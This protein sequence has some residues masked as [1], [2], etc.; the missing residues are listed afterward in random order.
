MKWFDDIPMVRELSL[1]RVWVIG[2][3]HGCLKQMMELT[4]AITIRQDNPDR[5]AMVFV[6]DICDRGPSSYLTLSTLMF[7]RSSSRYYTVLGNHDSKLLRKLTGK[8][9]KLSNGLQQTWDEIEANC[10]AD[11][12]AAIRRFFEN[13][14]F[15]IRVHTPKGDCVIAHAGFHQ[16]FAGHAGPWTKAMSVQ[17]AIFGPTDGVLEDGFPNRLPWENDYDGEDFVFYGHKAVGK[18][19]KFVGMTC[20]VDTG[21]WESGI[22]TAVSYPDLDVIQVSSN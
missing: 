16:C 7:L 1:D 9:V 19:P 15:T 14:P 2:D 3:L 17:Y 20:G 6:G 5:W 11:N 8:D 13:T 4:T 22:L 18:V 12:K 21:C 10:D